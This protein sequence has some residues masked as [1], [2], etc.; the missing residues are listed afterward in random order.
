MTAIYSVLWRGLYWAGHE[1]CQLTSLDAGW[2]LRGSA[3]FAHEQQ[4]CR[5]DYL[6]VCDAGWHTR[7]AT[8]VGWV[9][10]RPI[11]VD[12]VVEA[13]D[14]W[15]LNGN[16]QPQVAGCTDLDLNFSPS[17][18]TLPIRRLALAL[19]Q[20]AEV[21]AAWLRFPSF[22]LEPLPQ[23]YR[24]LAESTYRYESAGGQFVADLQVGS[25]GCVTSYP[26]LW[27]AEALVEA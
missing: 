16:P 19:G 4:P 10:N 17:T 11:T 27:Q 21:R 9:G 2:Q 14:L 18:N 23:V 6:I 8:V 24:R 3:V 13:A 20:A 26:G 25:S 7:R 5:L 15:R 12:L 1:A 22:E